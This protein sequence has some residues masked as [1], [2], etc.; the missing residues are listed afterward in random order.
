MQN[1]R[2]SKRVVDA[3]LPGVGKVAEGGEPSE[4]EGGGVGTVHSAVLVERPNKSLNRN[5]G[6]TRPSANPGVVPTVGQGVRKT[7]RI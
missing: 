6:P 5:S 1:S 4:G 3:T 7:G 2:N